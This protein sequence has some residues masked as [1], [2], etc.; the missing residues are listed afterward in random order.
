VHRYSIGFGPPILSVRRGETDYSIGALPLGGFVRIHGMDPHEEG[1]DPTDPRSY[2]TRP[3][4]QRALIIFAGPFINYLFALLLAFGLYAAGTHLPVPLTV[5]AVATGSPAA[6]AQLRPGDVL[7][8]IG[9]QP[10]EQWSQLVEAVLA[11]DGLPLTLTVRRA[12]AELTLTVTPRN[13]TRGIPR[14]GVAQQYVHRRLPLGEAAG[15]ALG[16]VHRLITEPF[17][18]LARGL[19][20]RPGLELVGPVAIVQQASDAASSGADAFLRVLVAIS[21]A[22]ALFNLLPIPALDG[23]RLAFIG[24]EAATGRKVSP[25]VETIAHAVGFLALIALLL[26]VVAKDIRR[27]LVARGALPVE[28]SAPAPKGAALPEGG[29]PEGEVPDAGAPDAGP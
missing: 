5:G 26:G 13:D 7:V 18:L 8:R 4:W 27:L 21:A 19:Q 25:R 24:L 22:L 28:T 12:E 9:G 29:L 10:A 6:R 2:A 11:S 3:A 23:G 1:L 15:A 17:V 16:H 14:I 20:G